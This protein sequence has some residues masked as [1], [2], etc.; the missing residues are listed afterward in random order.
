M[1]Y[2]QLTLFDLDKVPYGYCPN[3]Y[4]PNGIGP[5]SDIPKL[6]CWDCDTVVDGSRW[7]KRID[8][9]PNEHLRNLIAKYGY[10]QDEE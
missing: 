1:K 8:P 3:C 6:H 7:E 2:E 4:S 5:R 10:S 9:K